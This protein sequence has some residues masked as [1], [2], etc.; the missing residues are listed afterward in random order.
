MV[1]P[2]ASLP[3]RLTRTYD[4]RYA[5]GASGRIRARRAHHPQRKIM[6]IVAIAG[7]LNGSEPFDGRSAPYRS[8]QTKGTQPEEW[9]IP[10]LD[11]RNSC[12]SFN[13]LRVAA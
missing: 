11:A 5:D 8:V 2:S 12:A 13:S 1:W 10:A 7:G 9:S 3:D 4:A 6:T